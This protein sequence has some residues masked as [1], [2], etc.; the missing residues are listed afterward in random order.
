MNGIVFIVICYLWPGCFGYL[1]YLCLFWIVVYCFDV[2]LCFT[3]YVLDCNVY[4]FSYYCLGCVW[5]LLRGGLAFG[6]S[7]YLVVLVLIAGWAIR[8]W[9]LFWL[10]F[11][12][13]VCKL[14][15][16]LFGFV[17]L[18]LCLGV[19]LRFGLLVLL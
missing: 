12:L 8:W 3:I 17:W 18:L 6:F 11:C 19:A 16:F 10:L 13:V 7:G 14:V 1:R 15:E 9:C 4:L 5:L 2:L